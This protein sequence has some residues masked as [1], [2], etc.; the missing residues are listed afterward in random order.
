[1][2]SENYYLEQKVVELE[3][4][5][6]Q[7]KNRIPDSK[8]FSHKFLNRAFAVL[9]HNMIAGLLISIPLYILLFVIAGLFLGNTQF[10]DYGY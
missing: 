9:G 6:S 8:L 10:F 1:M 4:E 7:L 2:E 3:N 5:I